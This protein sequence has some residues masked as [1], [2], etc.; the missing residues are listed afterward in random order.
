MEATHFQQVSQVYYYL[1]K[2]QGA[3]DI[4][5]PLRQYHLFRSLSRSGMIRAPHGVSIENRAAPHSVILTA[6]ASLFPRTSG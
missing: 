5:R 3:G 2:Q 4:L 1:S 6:S